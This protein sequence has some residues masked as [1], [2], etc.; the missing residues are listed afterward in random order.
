Q[1]EI[2]ALNSRMNNISK[3]QKVL[4]EKINQA[5]S[6]AKTLS[7]EISDLN[8]EI[9]LIDEQIIVTDALIAQYEALMSEQEVQ[10]KDL[11]EK[12]VKEKKILDQMIR[13]SFEYSGTGSAI[14]FIFSAE[15]FGDLLSRIDLL[16]YHLSYNDKVIEN[17]NNSLVELEQTKASYEAAQTTLS[18]YRDEQAAR[19]EEL[20]LKKSEA[21]TK[22][23]QLLDNAEEYEKDLAEKQKYI[24]QLDNEIKQL[25]AMFAKED[26]TTYSGTFQF[27]L[28]SGVYTITSYYGNRKDPFTG[29]ASN[30]SGYDFACAKGT[31][32]FAADS[33]TVVIA[34]WNGGYGNCVMIN[35]G[36]GIMTL[37]GHC[38]ELL[39]TSGQ[40]VSRGDVI[41][42]VGSTGRS[43]GNHLHFEV[44]KNGSIIDPSPYIGIK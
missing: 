34:K 22:K 32:I 37:Y 28:P 43:T 44:R 26:K 20:G 42:K 21:E 23:K 27:P 31:K 41:A 15:D 39:V 10:I 3:E 25:A 24:N 12:L 7:S 17:Y 2:D 16:G 11:E 13:L 8:Y 35:H 30:H 6:A 36:G 14:E 5:Q 9:A 18:N 29:K 33:G 19:A 38:S 40:K 4:K 1:S